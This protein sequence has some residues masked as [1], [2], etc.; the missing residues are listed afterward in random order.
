AF[1]GLQFQQV[2]LKSF[3]PFAPL[4]VEINEGILFDECLAQLLKRVRIIRT[5]DTKFTLFLRSGYDLV[6]VAQETVALR[7]RLLLC[8]DQIS[9][10]RSDS[11]RA[12]CYP[13]TQDK[14]KRCHASMIKTHQNP[15]VDHGPYSPCPC[16]SLG[17]S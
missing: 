3:H 13:Q 8:R 17:H 9:A 2:P 16:A 4:H 15:P 1:G 14:K 12:C 7:L 11:S 6:P 10:G 5:P